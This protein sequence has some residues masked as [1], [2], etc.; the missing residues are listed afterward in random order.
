MRIK[1]SV[2]R[3]IF[4]VFNTCFLLFLAAICVLPFIHVLA[5][6]FSSKLPASAGQVGLWPVGFTLE[7]YNFVIERSEFYTAL[8]VTF[9]RLLIGVPLQMTVLIL[10]AYPLSRE[11]REFRFR[12]V[13]VWIFVITMFLGGGLVPWYIT[14][15]KLGL[16]DSIW[17]LVLPNAVQVFSITILL[18]FFRG[19]P[20][21]LSESAMI[22]GASHWT[23]L[24]R[25]YLPLSTPALAT[26]VLFSIV[27][28][29][30]SWFDGL[31]LMHRARNYPLQSYMYT[32][33]VRMSSQ[34]LARMDVEALR[35]I[36][37]STARSAQIFVSAIPVILI[38][39]FL[40]KY[41]T[42]GL[43]IGSVKE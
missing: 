7:S 11:N 25:I 4:V 41:F 1:E 9:R 21:E 20:K 37:T 24:L 12:T 5:L 29:W 28:H 14:I 43:V 17:A 19:L 33:V 8:L 38:Y 6:S 36:A 13:Y 40:Q 22:D 42:K 23:V 18:N 34:F 27:G 32:T 2:G 39:P 30:N 16:I 26:L 10:A 15:S 31:I 35:N 3:K